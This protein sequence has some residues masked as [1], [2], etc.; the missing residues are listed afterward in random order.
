M[1]SVILKN[2]GH[3][4]QDRV[5]NCFGIYQLGQAVSKQPQGPPPSPQLELLG[6]S[7]VLVVFYMVSGLDLKSSL[8]ASVL[9]WHNSSASSAVLILICF[10]FLRQDLIPGWPYTELVPT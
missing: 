4:L 8:K 10:F 6:Y 9:Q 7:T 1:L 2:T 3:M 5:S